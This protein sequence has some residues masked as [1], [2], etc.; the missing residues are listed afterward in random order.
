MRGSIQNEIVPFI[1]RNKICNISNVIVC[2]VKQSTL[3]IKKGKKSYKTTNIF[4]STQSW[5]IVCRYRTTLLESA[6]KLAS[7]NKQ[8]RT[9][10]WTKIIMSLKCDSRELLL[11][12][13]HE[14]SNVKSLRWLNAEGGE[15]KKKEYQCMQNRLD[16]GMSCCHKAC[17]LCVPGDFILMKMVLVVSCLLSLHDDKLVLYRNMHVRRAFV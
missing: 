13:I 10:T 5:I 8:E 3:C 1:I 11:L 2:R 17:V 4:K 16:I 15:T 14:K 12:R 7:D 9:A 6:T